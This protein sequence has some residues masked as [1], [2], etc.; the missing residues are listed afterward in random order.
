MRKK[1]RRRSENYE[2]GKGRPPL[3]TRWKPGQSGN[4]RGR[5]KGAKSL[6]TLF[7]DVLNRK[8]TIQENGKTRTITGREGIVIRVF[9]AALKGDPKALA[10]ILGIEPEIARNAKPIETY[11]DIDPRDA[12]KAYFEMVRGGTRGG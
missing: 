11:T 10:F 1:S 4:P 5:P 6:A 9:N 8:L 12:A 3:S 7:N 2:V